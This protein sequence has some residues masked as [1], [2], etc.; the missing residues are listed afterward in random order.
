MNA[1]FGA[2]LAPLRFRPRAF[3]APERFAPARFD[4]D[5]FFELFLDA[6]RLDFFEARFLAPPFL[7][8]AID[9]LSRR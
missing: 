9:C 7:V 5:L 8:V 4:P 2:R 1:G 3:F 6:P